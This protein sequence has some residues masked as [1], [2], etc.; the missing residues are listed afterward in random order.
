MTLSE[1]IQLLSNRL[2]TLNVS[3]ANAFALGD[4]ARVAAIEAE[5]AET[6]DTLARI[7]AM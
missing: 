1:V 7:R 3:R 4:A 2:A 6:E 5:I